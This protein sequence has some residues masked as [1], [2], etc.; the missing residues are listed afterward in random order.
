MA[1]VR[2]AVRRVDWRFLLDDAQLRTVVA[3]DGSDDPLLIEGVRQLGATVQADSTDADG[4]SVVFVRDPDDDDIDRALVRRGQAGTIVIETTSRRA[5]RD[6]DRRIRRT[7]LRVRHY[8]CWPTCASATRFVPLDDR[9]ELIASARAAK[10]R[11]RRA[12]GTVLT[13]FGLG[14]LLFSQ[15]T[16]VVTAA[17]RPHVEAPLRVGFVDGIE[18]RGT[19][20]L[21]TPRFGS[22]RHVIAMITSESGQSLVVKTPR[23]PGDDDQLSLE[24]RGLTSISGPRPMRPELVADLEQ[25]G[26][27]WLVQTRISGVP[28]APARGTTS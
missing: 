19:V 18:E 21:L 25:F 9:S 10:N 20:T 26:Q 13:R 5:R 17:D 4:A 22:S 3:L 16:S 24:A 8:G 15:S 14:K 11:R 1:L 27:R 23:V 2:E 28:L 7:G 6:V 12:V